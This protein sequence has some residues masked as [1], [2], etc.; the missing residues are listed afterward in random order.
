M[1]ATY[2]VSTPLAYVIAYGTLFLIGR[3]F[4]SVSLSDLAYHNG[5]EHD[6]SLTRQNALPAAKH[7]PVQ[8][9]PVLCK[10]LRRLLDAVSGSLARFERASTDQDT[11][12]AGVSTSIV[13][14]A[15]DRAERSA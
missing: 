9:C 11:V 6:A 3:L 1:K 4:H 12:D 14:D 13:H 7:G 2:N 8:A 15:G 5:V 10:Q